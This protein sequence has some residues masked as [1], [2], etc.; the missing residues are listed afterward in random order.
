VEFM[1]YTAAWSSNAAALNYEQQK[2]TS[3]T[4]ALLN[5][6]TSLSVCDL[7]QSLY[8]QYDC[9]SIRPLAYIENHTRNFTKFL[10]HVVYGSGSVLFWHRCDILRASGFV[11]DVT[12]SHNGSMAHL[13]CIT[14][15]RNKHN[16]RDF[17]L[18]LLN[19]K[20]QQDKR[21][22]RTGVEVCYLRLPCVV[23]AYLSYHR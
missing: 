11:D 7:E 3:I 22:L 9:L 19:D 20:G 8:D 21:E 13:M 15:E 1:L 6:T 17:N 2:F 14:T 5:A 4:A 12:F 23:F 10:V 18:I 16:G